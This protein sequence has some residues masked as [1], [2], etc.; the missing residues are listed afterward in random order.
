MKTDVETTAP[1]VTT[2][3]PAPKPKPKPKPTVTV[4]LPDTKA[5]A[6]T[7]TQAPGASVSSNG[8]QIRFTSNEAGATLA[9]KLDAAGLLRVHKPHRARRSRSR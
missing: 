4:P 3:K 1:Q 7:I 8:A 2:P 9:C 5:P 6:V